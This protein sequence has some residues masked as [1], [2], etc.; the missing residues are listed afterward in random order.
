[1]AGHLGILGY[2]VTLY[3][4]TDEKLDGVR[5]RGGIK[6]DGAVSGFGPVRKATSDVREAVAEADVVMVVTPATAHHDLAAAMAPCLRDGQL[7]VL[8]PGRTGGALEF[9]RVF[10]EEGMRARIVLAETQNS[11]T[12]RVP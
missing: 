5:W 8:N 10:R 7:V 11:C 9:R 3:N 2:P 12:P 4:R 1:M 6:V